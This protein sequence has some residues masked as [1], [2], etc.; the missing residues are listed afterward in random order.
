MP[1]LSHEPYNIKYSRIIK[2]C[3]KDLDVKEADIKNIL[4]GD[5]EAKKS[6]LFEKILLNSRALFKDLEVFDKAELAYLLENYKAPKQKEIYALR[7]KNIAEAWFFDKPLL[8][9]D[10]QWKFKKR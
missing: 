4:L 1:E 5:D 3:F 6:M 7:R 8:T 10:Y 9:G 2:D